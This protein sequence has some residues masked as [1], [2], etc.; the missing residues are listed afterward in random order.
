LFVLAS[1]VGKLPAL[2]LEAYAVYQ[3]TAFGWQGKLILA[4]VAVAL[5]VWVLRRKQPS[6][7]R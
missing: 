5:I 6:Q 4:V 1:S 3:V 7:N 2:L